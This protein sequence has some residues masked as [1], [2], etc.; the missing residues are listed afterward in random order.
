MAKSVVV[1]DRDANGCGGL[2]M[3]SEEELGM[4]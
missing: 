1:V 4:A 2:E 3:T